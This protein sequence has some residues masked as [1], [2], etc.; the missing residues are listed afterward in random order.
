MNIELI[1]RNFGKDFA[2][3]RVSNKRGESIIRIDIRKYEEIYYLLD[4]ETQYVDKQ[5]KVQN[6]NRIH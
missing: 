3:M 1:K 2:Y 5:L 6:K 4:N